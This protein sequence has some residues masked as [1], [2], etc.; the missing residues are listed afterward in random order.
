MKVSVSKRTKSVK[1]KESYESVA[2]KFGFK[3]PVYQKYIIIN[4]VPH[5]AT[6][7]GLVPL[8]KVVKS[9]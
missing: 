4:G 6:A 8:T 5:K 7:E 9:I 1:G 3:K 2:A